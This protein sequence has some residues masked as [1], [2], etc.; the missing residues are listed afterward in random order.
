MKLFSSIA[1]YYRYLKTWKK[2][3]NR[4]KPEN[5]EQALGFYSQFLNA[6]DICFDVGANIGDK[7]DLFVNLGAKVVAIEPQE[8]CWR[9]LKRRF[10]NQ[11]VTIEPVALADEKGTRTLFVDRSVTLAT[12]SKTWIDSVKKSGRFPRHKW[13]GK[14][15]VQT[16][17]LDMLIEKYGKP[18]FCKIDVEGFEFD[19]LKGLSKPIRMISLE[20][21]SERTENTLSCIDH[22]AKLGNTE[23]NYCMNDS[24]VFALPK[25]LDHKNIKTILNEM[26]KNIK[27]YGD[28]YVH[29]IDE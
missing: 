1:Q 4:E 14:L 27:N 22:L 8:S 28:I 5:Y 20:F 17:T 10:K 12:M 15:A 6:G 24:S 3:V 26:D 9:I 25:W 19:V 2:V 7:C 21:V 13:N 11:N 16:V 23:F 29:F 18:A